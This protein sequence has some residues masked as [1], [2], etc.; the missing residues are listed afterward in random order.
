MYVEV[1]LESLDGKDHLDTSIGACRVNNLVL[2]N[3]HGICVT[4]SA[5]AMHVHEHFGIE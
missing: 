1:S 5:N 4:V 2:L 3:F